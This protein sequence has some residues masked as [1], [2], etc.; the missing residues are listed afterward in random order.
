MSPRLA[1][2]LSRILFA[3][4]AGCFVAGAWLWWAD[5][6][7]VSVLKFETPV[8]VGTLAVDADHI[9]EIPV[10]NTGRETIRLV[11]LDGEEC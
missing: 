8:N 6:P 5:R 11:G 2:W 10:A 4:A 1:A 3:V 7:P 9:V